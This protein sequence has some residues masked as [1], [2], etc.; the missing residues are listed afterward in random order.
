VEAFLEERYDM[1]WLH[2]FVEGGFNSELALTFEVQGIPK[3]VLV[4][5]QGEIVAVG[6]ALRGDQLS[7]TLSRHLVGG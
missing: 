1:P 4:N 7:K 3:P 6:T 5:P 2:A